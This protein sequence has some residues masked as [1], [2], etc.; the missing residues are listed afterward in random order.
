M[1]VVKKRR[2]MVLAL[3]S[4]G[5]LMSFCAAQVSGMPLTKNCSSTK[6]NAASEASD[7][8]EQ[9]ETETGSLYM[10]TKNEQLI[11]SA[12]IFKTDAAGRKSGSGTALSWAGL[13][14]L[15]AA[16]DDS[17]ET[18]DVES[19]NNYSFIIECYDKNGT[20]VFTIYADKEWNI[21]LPDTARVTQKDFCKLIR[22]LIEDRTPTKQE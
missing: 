14:K 9:P 7:A 3:L 8:A 18:E 16:L 1:N 11:E 5:C 10:E 17:P 20:A 4:A 13:K 21:Y 19:V 6:I 22:R 2:G 12:S 15:K